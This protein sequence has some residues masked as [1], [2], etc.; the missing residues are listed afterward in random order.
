V[1]RPISHSL[2]HIFCTVDFLYFNAFALSVSFDHLQT[3]ALG[4]AIL[5]T[6]GIPKMAGMVLNYDAFI[7]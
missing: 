5:A 1:L 3:T 2:Q 4:R 7:S 6:A